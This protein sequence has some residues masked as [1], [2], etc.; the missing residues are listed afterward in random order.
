MIVVTG[1][2]LLLLLL[3]VGWNV[4]V[5]GR[6][7]AAAVAASADAKLSGTKSPF[8]A[9]IS[10]RWSRVLPLGWLGVVV[11]PAQ[12]AWDEEEEGNYRQKA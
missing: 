7:A 1:K 11:P 3:F 12:I 10:C 8:A 2:L 9:H 6:A 5:A 4:A